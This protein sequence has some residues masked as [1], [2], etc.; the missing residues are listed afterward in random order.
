MILQVHPRKLRWKLMVQKSGDHH[1]TSMKPCIFLRYFNIY[2]YHSNWCRISSIN[3]R[4][5]KYKLPTW[6]R[7]NIDPTNLEKEK[8]RPKP[9]I[10]GFQPLIFRECFLGRCSWPKLLVGKCPLK[11]VGFR[12]REVSPLNTSGV[13]NPQPSNSGK[14]QRKV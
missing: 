3:S 8:H 4:I 14:P 9:P 12:I 5:W 1:L 7:R 11:W 10:L 6:K 13:W 2:I